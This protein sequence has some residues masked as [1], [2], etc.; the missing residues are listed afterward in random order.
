MVISSSPCPFLLADN[1]CEIYDGRPR[2]CREYPHTDNY[3]FLKNV[4]L[5]KDNVDYCPAVYHIVE[6]LRLKA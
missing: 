1:N 4:R 2:A 3:E 5:H 6:G